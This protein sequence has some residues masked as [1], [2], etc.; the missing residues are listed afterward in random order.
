MT[1]KHLEEQTTEKFNENDNEKRANKGKI[2][3]TESD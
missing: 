1:K 2:R 3:S